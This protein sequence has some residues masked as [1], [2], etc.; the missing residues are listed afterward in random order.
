VVI[1]ILRSQK[2]P[3]RSA[4]LAAQGHELAKEQSQDS[5]ALE[6]TLRPKFVMNNANDNIF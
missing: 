6:A 5:N 1:V 2:R 4:G 3:G